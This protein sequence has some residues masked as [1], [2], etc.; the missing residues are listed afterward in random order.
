[1]VVAEAGSAWMW[2]RREGERMRSD[3]STC[4]EDDSHRHPQAFQA[5]LLLL[6]KAL[7]Q[8]TGLL[9]LRVNDLGEALGELPADADGAAIQNG[10]TYSSS[11]VILARKSAGC[12]CLLHW[13]ALR[14]R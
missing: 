13:V 12:S 1:M 14:G 10:K 6:T 5:L 4:R 3:G 11:F 2:R 7:R 9:A 8:R